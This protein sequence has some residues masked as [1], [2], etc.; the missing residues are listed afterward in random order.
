MYKEINYDIRDMKGDR[1][2]QIYTIPVFGKIFH[3]I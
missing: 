3:F 2:M 1:N